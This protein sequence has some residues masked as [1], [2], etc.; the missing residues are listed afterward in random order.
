M[1]FNRSVNKLIKG[2]YRL[3][4]E[5]SVK[6]FNQELP[7]NNPHPKIECKLIYKDV[8]ELVR[9]D[10]KLN[11][12]KRAWL[13]KTQPSFSILYRSY[14]W[15]KKNLTGERMIVYFVDVETGAHGIPKVLSYFMDE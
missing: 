7:D 8:L 2:E 15:L 10:S 11:D 3:H 14:V 13:L 6:R 5:P 4:L 9:N 1:S 12:E